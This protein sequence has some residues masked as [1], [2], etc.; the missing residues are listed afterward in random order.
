MSS[1][2]IGPDPR[3]GS[4]CLDGN[5]GDAMCHTASEGEPQPWIRIRLDAPFRVRTVVIANRKNCCSERIAGSEIRIGNQT[6]TNANPSCAVVVN[7]GGV[8]DCDLRGDIVIIRRAT[9]ANDIY[10]IMEIAI[11]SDK[12]IC[13]KGVASQSS[14][15][16]AFDA[17]RAQIPVPLIQRVERSTLGKYSFTVQGELNPCYKVDLKIDGIPIKEVILFGRDH[18]TDEAASNDGYEVRIGDLAD[19]YDNQ[20]CTTGAISTTNGKEVSC[21]LPG[22]YVGIVRPGTD[23]LFLVGIWASRTLS[24]CRLPRTSRQP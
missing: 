4:N 17:T 13:P 3:P 12:N 16:G 1:E 5:Y 8:Y 19:P 7:D 23:S 18:E 6:D 21:N 2:H 11:W 10:N 22:I 20:S 15:S 9:A 24:A 14:T